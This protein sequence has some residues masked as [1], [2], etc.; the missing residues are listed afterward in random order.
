MASAKLKLL[1]SHPPRINSAGF[2]IGTIPFKGK[3]TSL[4]PLRPIFVVEDYVMEP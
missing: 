4:Q 1:I 3:N 2:T